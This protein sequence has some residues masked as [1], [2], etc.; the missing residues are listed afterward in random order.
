DLI[1]VLE[2]GSLEN[3]GKIYEQH[4]DVFFETPK[5]NIDNK[6]NNEYFG[7]INLV[8]VT[9]TSVAEILAELLQKYEDQ[10]IDEDVATCLLAGIISK[11]HS[12]QHVLTTPK[13]FLKASELVALG[14][15]Q[16]EVVKHIYKTKSLPLL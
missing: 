11:T 16:Q 1:I 15:R 13:A 14:G 6:A 9:A 5:I 2:A 3:L 12:F 10:L 4:T 7:A 8:D